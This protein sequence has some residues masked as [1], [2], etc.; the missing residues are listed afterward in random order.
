MVSSFQPEDPYKISCRL[1]MENLYYGDETK[2]LDPR[3][4]FIIQGQSNIPVYIWKGGNA[5]QGSLA[6]Y[7]EEARKHI[8]LL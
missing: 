1:I 3:A 8:K 2:K 7:M 6:P 5:P 4:V